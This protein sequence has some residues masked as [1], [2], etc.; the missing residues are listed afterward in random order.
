LNSDSKKD[1]QN[2]YKSISSLIHTFNPKNNL[3]NN[4]DTYLTGE[5]PYQSNIYSPFSSDID[6]DMISDD[7]DLSMFS[8]AI[9]YH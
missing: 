8:Q 7:F 4:I 6:T 1:I 3:N 5:D 9:L 2:Y